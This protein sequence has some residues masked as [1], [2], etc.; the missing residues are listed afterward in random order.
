MII[1]F[2]TKVSHLFRFPN[3]LNIF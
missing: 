1:S 3:G 2:F